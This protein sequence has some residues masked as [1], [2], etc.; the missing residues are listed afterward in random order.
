[1]F[2]NEARKVNR[3][4][5]RLIVGRDLVHQM[6]AGSLNQESYT[7]GRSHSGGG[8]VSSLGI[9]FRSRRRLSQSWQIEIAKQILQDAGVPI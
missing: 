1:M 3:E 7:Y 8:C 4:S 5:G 2:G 9:T 6:M